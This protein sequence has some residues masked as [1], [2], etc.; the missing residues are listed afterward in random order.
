MS[1]V[2][3]AAKRKDDRLV[4]ANGDRMS[5]EIKRLAQGQLSFKADYMLSAINIDWRRVQELQSL[6]EFQ[7]VLSSGQHVTGTIERR[8]DGSF[9][10]RPA[11]GA[12]LDHVWSEVLGL[13]PVEA[14]FWHQLTGNLDSGFSYTS[15]DT[16]TQFSASGTLEYLAERY[17]IGFAGSSTYSGQE[18]G[19]TTTRNT[20]DTLG[21]LIVRPQWYALGLVTLLS[22]E[23]QDL[24]LRTTVGGA[25]GRW[26][27]R[28]E[29]TDLTVFGGV[30]YNHE[31]YSVPPDP[32]QP[33]SQVADNIE[34]LLGSA[35]SFVRFKSTKVV[36]RFAIFPSLTTPG[37]V[38]LTYTPT[39]NLEIAHNL[40]WSFT[41]YENYDSK[42]PVNA[43]KNDFGVTNS[44][45]W[46]F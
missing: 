11:A 25:L 8:P 21:Q 2:D 15:G 20:V 34:A 30:A 41:L 45:G 32:S 38:R 12:P 33:G 28:T 5:G 36:S 16:Q 37:R 4:L 19:T 23:Q 1:A 13:L 27:I 31:Q 3:A 26:L 9:T 40:Y 10:V 42:P 14:S 18:S 29:H 7:V 44:I 22:S 35:Y 39:L 43:N 46:K 17:T 24:S 6:D